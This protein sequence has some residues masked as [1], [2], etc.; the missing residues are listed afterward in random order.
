[1]MM[2]G[3]V[4]RANL[5]MLGCQKERE[6]HPFMRQAGYVKVSAEQQERERSIC[7][8]RHRLLKKDDGAPAS[9][10]RLKTFEAQPHWH[11]I[12]HEYYYVLEGAGHIVI[13]G[14]KVEVSAGD[15]VWIR[16]GHIHHA[17]GDLESLIIGIP[18]FDAE[19]VFT[20]APPAME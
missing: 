5:G 20:D 3:R 12:S 2:N 10:T 1:M 4:V 7:G 8:F 15:C 18:P 17:E 16:P 19:D 13:D 14:A 9:L 6:R 11:K